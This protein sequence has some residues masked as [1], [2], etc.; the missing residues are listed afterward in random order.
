MKSGNKKS[1]IDK[2]RN[3]LK[4]NLFEQLIKYPI[5]QVACERANISR[6]TYYRWRREDK[7]FAAEADKAV[8]SG[9]LFVNDIAESQLIHKIKDANM[10]AIIFWLKNHHG[11]Y[12]EKIY[13]EHEIIEK[14]EFTPEMQIQVANAMF[15]GGLLTKLGRDIQIE[16]A[17]KQKADEFRIK[18]E[19]DRIFEK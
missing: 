11:R 13:H 3:K 5:V 19:L 15:N 4:E 7:I 14:R 10:T 18:K 8:E 16:T 17:E 6:A 2:K 1:K 9:C 12:N